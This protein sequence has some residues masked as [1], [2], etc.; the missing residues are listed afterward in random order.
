MHKLLKLNKHLERTRY[1][2]NTNKKL[3]DPCYIAERF[4][5]EDLPSPN[6]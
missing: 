1:Q 3:N 4:D 6:I 5:N 2:I